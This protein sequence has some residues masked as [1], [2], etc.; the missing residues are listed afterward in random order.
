MFGLRS[1]FFASMMLCAWLVPDAM[2]QSAQ[3]PAQNPQL[4]LTTPSAAGGMQML[5]SEASVLFSSG[6]YPAAAEVYKRLLQLGSA[7][8]SD[9]YWLGESLYHTSNFQQAATAYEQAIQV[10]RKMAQAYVRLAESYLAL[11][12]KERALQACKSGLDVVT[13]PYMKDQL[14][15]LLKVSFYADRKPTRSR[16]V[17][18]NRLPSES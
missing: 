15:N 9:R 6:Q 11:R 1:L 8:A 7:D 13:D 14:S 2:A 12:Q 4:A 5:R 17:R 16:D 3:Y 10:D 18:S